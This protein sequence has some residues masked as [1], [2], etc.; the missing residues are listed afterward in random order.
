MFPHLI[1]WLKQLAKPLTPH[2]EVI[3]YQTLRKT[4]GWLGIL[5]PFAMILGAE[6][7]SGCKT[8][9]P[10]I[11]HYYYT[12]MREIFVGILCAVSLFLFSY[13]GYSLL[14]GIVSNLAVLFCLG[15]ALFPT[16]ARCAK[17]ICYP[18]QQNV[19]SLTK[20]PYHGTI[21]LV[22]A[23]LFFFTLAMMS[24]FLFRLSNSPKQ[25]QTPQKRNRNQVFLLCGIVMLASILAC[26]IYIAGANE[27]DT[28]TVLV[29][30]TV[31]LLA[32]GIS[33]LTK[34]EAILE[35]K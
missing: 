22:C 32:F 1:N 19:I 12:N 18:C 35:D 6:I 17:G 10:S 13:K 4:I 34:G 16:E 26:G 27:E 11:S 23:G 20:I 15:V 31:A 28:V 3:S 25:E 21:H 33:W 29:L 14:D 8:V 24:I 2:P 7:F 30:E 9:Q 5:L